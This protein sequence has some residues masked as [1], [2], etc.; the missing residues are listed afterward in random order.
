MNDKELA[1]RILELVG[2][3]ANLSDVTHCVTRLRLSF[4]DGDKIQSNEISALPGVL[5]VNTVGNQ[6]QVILGGKVT[7][8][9]EAFT[10]LVSL[11]GSNQVENDAPKGNLID[12]FL[13]TLSGI[14]VPII[15]AIIGAG[16]IKGVLF[17]LMF[18]GVISSDSENFQIINVFSDAAFYFIPVLIAN[19]TANRFK[20]NP[21][22]AMAIAGI[23][24]HPTMVELM[25]KH[26]SVHLFGIP[27]T[28]ASYSSSVLPM[29]MAVG[30][31]IYVERFL[32]LYIPKILQT[33]LVPLLTILIVAPVVLGILGPLG[34]IIG[35]GIGQIFIKFYM[36]QSWLAGAVISAVYPFMVILGMHV[37]FTPVMVQNLS[38]Y[39]VDYLMALFVAS[40]AAQAG[41]TFAVFTKTKN[42]EFKATAGTAAFN[43]FL[44]ITEPAL[45]GVTS[46]LK[47]P[48][49]AVAIGGAVGGVIAGA[50][51]V[52]ALGMGTGPIA[53]LPLFFGK[54]FIYYII[55]WVVAL[56]IG[57]VL[58]YV[59][60]FD[61]IPEKGLL[62]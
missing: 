54:T 10:S 51:R 52:E 46:R 62:K 2:D 8:V 1:Q 43:A 59:I 40:N 31:Q 26:S 21:Y 12:R 53:G 9:Y 24:I 30:F 20:V 49:I 3:E 29:I 58:T 15:P 14:F 5:G 18:F 55:S 6:F 13:D 27:F 39:G 32:K 7:S 19:S 45:F 16:M 25:S 22:I 11:D 57:F 61:D 56:V 4:K 23:L 28:S 38:Q 42:K 44:G 41:A 47:R 34:T 50:F 35:N 36:A 48:L 60:G 17:S 33:L 37:G